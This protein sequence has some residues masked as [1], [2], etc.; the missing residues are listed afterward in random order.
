MCQLAQLVERSPADYKVEGSIPA[1]D[2]LTKWVSKIG[3]TNIRGKFPGLVQLEKR[4]KL[5][6]LI[7]HYQQ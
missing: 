4:D 1:I 2:H 3:Q 6:P 7:G 5:P